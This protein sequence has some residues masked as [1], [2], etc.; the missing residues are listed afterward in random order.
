[1]I[2]TK[3][4]T[5]VCPSTYTNKVAVIK[6]IRSLSGMGL[7]EAK[8]VSEIVGAQQT[9]ELSSSLYSNYANPHVEIENHFRVLRNE[10]VKVGD[11]IHEILEDL[12][13]LA[14]QALQQGEDELANEILQLVLVEKL[15]RKTI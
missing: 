11:S 1:M 12:R 8:D 13:E 4:F 3:K 15:R 6:A 5:I 2:D 14:T 7:K 9:F 10:G